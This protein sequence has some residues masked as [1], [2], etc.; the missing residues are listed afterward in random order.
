[1][2]LK[3]RTLP[4]EQALQNL[5]QL[6]QQ[7]QIT[8][9]EFQDCVKKLGL[10]EMLQKIT[11]N[12]GGAAGSTLGSLASIVNKVGQSFMTAKDCLD[13]GSKIKGNKKGF[14]R[15]FKGGITFDERII[16]GEKKGLFGRKRPRRV[17][18]P[19]PMTRG[20]RAKDFI[21]AGASMAESLFR[22]YGGARMIFG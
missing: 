1:L 15:A 18:D 9:E 11:A 7:K 10:E 17:F 5:F 14:T 20:E 13:F 4:K 2:W 6:F 16:S 21:Y 22:I 8:R 12:N 3:L 19:R